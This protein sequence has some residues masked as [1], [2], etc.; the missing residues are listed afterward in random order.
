[1]REPGGA[2]G[3]LFE[4]HGAAIRRYLVGRVGPSHADDLLAETFL[5]AHR[6]WATFDPARG[7]AIGWL[8]GIAT[9]AVHSRARDEQR[10]LR[11]AACGPS[12][13]TGPPRHHRTSRSTG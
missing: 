1:M 10:H 6:R 3:V 13:R 2:V 4:Q 12:L 11:R 5:A 8:F 7:S 9:N